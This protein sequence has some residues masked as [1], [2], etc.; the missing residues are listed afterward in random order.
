MGRMTWTEH[1]RRREQDENRQCLECA[2]ANGYRAR[3][4]EDC[5]DGDL[6]CAGC[7]WAQYRDEEE[8]DGLD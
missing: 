6:E 8:D 1:E 2:E 5:E 3:E 7:P 4:A